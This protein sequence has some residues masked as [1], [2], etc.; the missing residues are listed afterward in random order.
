[1]FRTHGILLFLIFP[2]VSATLMRIFNCKEVEGVSYLA[3]DFRIACSDRN[4]PGNLSSWDPE[5]LTYFLIGA[6]FVIAYPIGIPLYFW[7]WLFC[8]K[9][10]MTGNYKAIEP[11]PCYMVP[12][13][14]EIQVGTVPVGKI[15]TSI[16][17]NNKRVHDVKDEHGDVAQ[18]IS[19]RKYVDSD[20][21]GD[22]E[23]VEVWSLLR[24]K[25]GTM[26]FLKSNASAWFE[27]GF[28]WLYRAYEGGYWFW[29]LIEFLR[30]FIL[31]SVI[32]FVVPGSIV[33]IIV[34]LV[35]C[36]LFLFLLSTFKPYERNSDDFFQS[37]AF[38][39]LNWTL[40]CGVTLRAGEEAMAVIPDHTI[41]VAML[42]MNFLVL[43]GGVSQV[44]AE[45]V[46]PIIKDYLRHCLGYAQKFNDVMP[47]DMDDIQELGMQA[48]AA[49][50]KGGAAAKQAAKAAAPHV[51]RAG[52]AAGRAASQAATAAREF[53]EDAVSEFDSESE[54]ES[55]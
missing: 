17:N 3:E 43:F 55:D 14:V 4:Q 46:W 48:E 23:T 19:H 54:T 16:G 1:M 29:E 38:F 51:Q 41:T 22:L 26:P 49:A 45:K 13:Q 34:G 8:N 27:Y 33:Q 39:T 36:S 6:L 35:V 24:D 32:I 31:S 5:Y 12:S 15:I 44:F 28:G 25:D 11:T 20:Q 30:K 37:L 40:I 2:G 53:V 18:W 10:K 50:R 47:E 7:T 42:G 52:K 9:R 21:D